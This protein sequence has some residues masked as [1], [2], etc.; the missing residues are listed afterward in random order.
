MRRP[1]SSVTTRARGRGPEA[2]GH[3]VVALA[4]DMGVSGDVDP[5]SRDGLGPWL[6]EP[7]LIASY[8]Q[9]VCSDFDR[10]SRDAMDSF[11]LREWLKENGKVL[12]N[13]RTGENVDGKTDSMVLFAVKA[14]IAEE[15][16]NKNKERQANA[17]AKVRENGGF[18][19][20]VPFGFIILPDSGRYNR[21]LAPDPALRETLRGLAERSLR[22]ESYARIAEWMD[23]IVPAPMAKH[24][25]EEA[26]QLRKRSPESKA[27][28]SRRHLPA[29]GPQPAS[30]GFCGHQH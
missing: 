6:T 4:A 20:R 26:K 13:F 7:D 5:F 23:T 30:E 28:P 21:C 15:E 12:H 27:H 29:S 22:N 1:E 25:G 8:D 14:A 19:G 3:E 9:L 2:N 16:L 24:A 17:R 18:V 10:V 11:K